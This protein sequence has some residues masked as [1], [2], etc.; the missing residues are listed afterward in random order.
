LMVITH[1]RATFV[2]LAVCL[3]NA[4]VLNWIIP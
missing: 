1:L 4:N 2:F 3:L